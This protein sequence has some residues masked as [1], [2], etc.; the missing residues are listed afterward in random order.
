MQGSFTMLEFPDPEDDELLFLENRATSV[1]TRDS[2][3]MIANYKEEFY[4]LETLAINRQQ[5]PDFLSGIADE[6]S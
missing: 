3:D 4:Q 6:M 5:L 2:L 1:S